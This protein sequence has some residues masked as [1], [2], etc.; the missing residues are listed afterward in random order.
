MNIKIKN[1]KIINPFET[2]ENASVE[3]VDGKISKITKE[4]GVANHVLIPGFIDT[5][6]HGFGGHD[7]MDGVKA[8]EEISKSL[9]KFGTTSFFP[10]AMTASWNDIIKSLENISNAQSLGSKIS[11]IHLEGPFISKIKKGAHDENF[12]I[13]LTKEK[14]V[15][16]IESSNNK[17]R[18][19]T[20]AATSSKKDVVQYF[21]EN[22]VVVSLGHDH[23]TSDDARKVIWHG[24]RS[25]THLWNAMT[26]VNNRNPGLVEAFLQ[27]DKVYTEL[28]TDLIH[29]DPEAI[30]LTIKCKTP[31]KVVVITDAIRPAGLENGQYTSGGLDVTKVNNLITLKNTNTIAGSGAT[32]HDNFINLI[33]LGVPINDV[34]KMTSYNAAKSSNLNGVGEIKENNIADFILLENNYNIY[35]VYIDGKEVK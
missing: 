31:D 18:K 5:H 2:I 14:A 23:G 21:V 10:T 17:L 8:T 4:T 7:C 27:D 3:I 26:G 29:V 19:I 25:A 28:I 6:I 9:A 30:K 20:I 35:K 13:D 24:A 34:V 32:M 22:N 16:L 15:Q 1:V 33:N 11:G 12:I